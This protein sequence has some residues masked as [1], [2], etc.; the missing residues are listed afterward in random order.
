[1]ADKLV[2]VQFGATTGAMQAGCDE[3][4]MV[5]RATANQ[6]TESFQRMQMQVAASMTKVQAE[7]KSG[8]A[9][10]NTA[11]GSVTGAIGKV[12]GAFIAITAVLAGGSAFK[13]AVSQTM[14]WTGEAIKLSR[15]LGVT[16]ERASVLVV[17][18]ERLG[19]SQEQISGSLKGL[20]RNLK[21]NE[22]GLN[23]MGIATKDANGKTLDMIE[24]MLNANKVLL[25]YKEGKDRDVAMMAVYGRAALDNAKFI[26]LNAEVMAEAKRRAEELHLVVGPEGV[27]QY[28]AYRLAM[29][30][31]KEVFRSLNIMIGSAVIPIL[32]QLGAWLGSQGPE[33]VHV[34][35]VAIQTLS[36]V[37]LDCAATAEIAYIHIST[38]FRMMADAATTSA[39]I[40]K[41][42]LQGDFAGV[43]HEGA[44]GWRNMGNAAQD[45]STRMKKVAVDTVDS[46]AKIL[47]LKGSKASSLGGGGGAQYD[48]DAKVDKSKGKK[49]KE[50]PSRVPEWTESLEIMLEKER[51]FFKD[52]KNEELIYWQEKLKVAD[53]SQ[54]ERI[55]INH[56]VYQL[57]KQLAHES[58]QAEIVVLKTKYDAALAGSIDRI[59]IVKQEAQRIKAAYGEQS[60]EYKSMLREIEKAEREHDEDVKKRQENILDHQRELNMIT[61]QMKRDDLDYLRNI[62]AISEQEYLARERKLVEQ[63]YQI[64]LQSLQNKVKLLRQGTIEHQKALLEIEKL[65][66]KHVANVHKLDLQASQDSIKSWQKVFQS[67]SQVFS[68]AIKGMINGT[69]TFK[70]AMQQMAAGILDSFVDMALQMGMEWIKQQI[71]MTLCSQA[72]DQTR[73]ASQTAA[74]VESQAIRSSANVAAV[75]SYTAVAAMAAAAAVASIPYAGPAL[76]A[77]AAAMMEGMGQGYAIQ[78]SAAKGYDI[79]A[80][81]NP[82]TQ[83]H[84]REM[85][86]PAQYADVIRNM[87]GGK[88]GARGGAVQH[89]NFNVN[90]ID[91]KSVKQFFMNNGKAIASTLA[92]QARNFNPQ[93][94]PV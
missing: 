32:T 4:V 24:I 77:A 40:V 94:N 47:G 35:K 82:V 62:E 66:K 75:E 48:D 16:T 72:Q 68:G 53:L 22:A 73:V 83:L 30:D 76:A 37:F 93:V 55:A 67:I 85:V 19:V 43:M 45:Y 23:Q 64:D 29:V 42:A 52:S 59:N 56:K 21:S 81:V 74:D 92:V 58:L 11:M 18:S 8:F 87:A 60:K 10:V 46:A 3:A 33:L 25:G 14:E 79:P 51:E 27:A 41:K 86:L 63:E 80:G 39:S 6:I 9:G 89:V 88:Q 50:T 44:Q 65:Q 38:A 91:T 57:E 31:V 5:S 78:A 54:K 1:M 15:Q 49:E 36:I 70:K 12:Q 71:M 26:Q 69:L 84:A 90:A 17:A 7:V 13:H 2:Q 34:F 20:V 61:V 28:K